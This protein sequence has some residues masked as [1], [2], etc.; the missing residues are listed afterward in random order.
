MK[1]LYSITLLGG[2][3]DSCSFAVD[4][5]LTCYSIDLKS[6]LKKYNNFDDEWYIRVNGNIIKQSRIS[7]YID[8]L[9]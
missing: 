4:D 9:G 8:S 5:E 7:N 1:T 2:L 3:T 6:V